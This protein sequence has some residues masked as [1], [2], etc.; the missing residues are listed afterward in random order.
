[1]SKDVRHLDPAS[2]PDDPALL[3]RL[4]LQDRDTLL[5]ERDSL[6]ARIR[7]E[8]AAQLEEREAELRARLEVEKRA[9]IAAEVAAI[10]RKYYRPR[11]ERF[12]PSQLLLFGQLVE[13][14]PIDQAAVTEEAGEEL[15]T[16]K[17]K[18]KNRDKHGRR[19]LPDHLPRI[20]IEHDLDEA[21]K[22][23]PCCGETRSRIGCAV[24]EQL[25]RI[26][27]SFQVLKHIRHQYACPRCEREAVN[28]Q[29]VAAP[30][31]K[32]PIEKGLPGPALLAYLIT[33]KFGEHLPLYRLE[34][35]FAREGV[36]LSRTTLCGWL[37]AIG[38][39]ARP[40]VELMAQRILLSLAIHSDDTTVPV[41][42]PGEG[43]CRT[44]RLWCYLGDRRHPYVVYDYRPDRK[45]DGPANWLRDYRG[46]L[47]ADA[48]GGYDGIYAGGQVTE[49]ACWAHAR[50]KF[51]DLPASDARRAWMLL[52]VREL[53][54]VE[55]DARELD[56]AARLSLRQSRSAPLLAEIKSW[57]DTERQVVLPRS[58]VAGAIGYALNQW[59]AL[60]VYT[61]QGFLNIDNNPAER[62]MRR[63][64][65]GRKNWLFAGNDYAGGT[66]ARLYSLIA[67]AERT[68]IDPQAYLT[69][70]LADLPVTP[71][72]EIGELLP[73][74]WARRQATAASKPS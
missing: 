27:A 62:A 73:D 36:P 50:R 41:Q 57:L 8:A 71:A 47:Q 26:P 14:A 52:R 56:D 33:S 68:G 66:A 61:T 12:N 13:A 6:I 21:E 15:I 43:K 18:R 10:L 34:K 70:I 23:C 16:P 19:P 39:L 24:S 42:A 30:K 48:Y 1:M 7:E 37:A 53:Y 5:A 54:A 60:T 11:S 9:E 72:A 32:Q 25:E 69:S 2:L 58:A 46:Y 45:R 28:P 49:V 17:K 55:E 38:E 51:F 59:A 67:S 40:L 65:V 31:P 44:G 74:A 29:I 35:I 22:G 64:A 3:K 4:W 63:V 20:E